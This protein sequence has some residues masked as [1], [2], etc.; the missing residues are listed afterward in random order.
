MT[1][2]VA[3]TK[4]IDTLI[5]LRLEYLA[6]HFG[7]LEPK[8]EQALRAQLQGYFSAH[9]NHDFLAV[10]C[11]DSGKVVS[12]AY[13][14]INEKP[15]NP[16]FITGKTATVLNVY[17]Y[18]EY[19]KRGCATQV[20]ELLIQCAKN[21]N[22]SYIELSATEAGKPLYEKLGFQVWQQPETEMRLQLT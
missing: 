18:P 14:A 4:D 10:L 21:M 1:V 2:R 17:T 11:E 9:L 19:R 22:I 12:T 3:E 15:A 6:H 7:R 8:A 13:L 5:K 16:R 20:L